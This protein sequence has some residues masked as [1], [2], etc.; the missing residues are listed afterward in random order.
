MGKAHAN[1][2]NKQHTYDSHNN[3]GLAWLCVAYKGEKNTFG[4][5]F[6]MVSTTLCVN[7]ECYKFAI[8]RLSLNSNWREVRGESR[9]SLESLNTCKSLDGYMSTIAIQYVNGM[10]NKMKM[11][12]IPNNFFYPTNTLVLRDC[13]KL[14]S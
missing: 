12:M 14:D 7:V 9:E 4:A 8:T 10:Q 1:V 13:V 2:R 5:C 3:A 6:V 11:S